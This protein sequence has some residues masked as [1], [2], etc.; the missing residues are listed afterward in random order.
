MYLNKGTQELKI[1]KLHLFFIIRNYSA[2]IILKGKDLI[3]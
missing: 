2:G 1:N 3:K